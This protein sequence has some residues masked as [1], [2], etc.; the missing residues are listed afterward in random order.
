[1]T[2]KLYQ[3]EKTIS[4]ILSIYVKIVT[5]FK[6]KTQ[7]VVYKLPCLVYNKLEIKRYR[8]KRREN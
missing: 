3:K 7:Y 5:Y 1:M 2:R 6:K 8:K 4:R